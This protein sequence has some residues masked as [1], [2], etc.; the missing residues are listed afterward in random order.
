MNACESLLITSLFTL[1]LCAQIFSNMNTKRFLT[2][3]WTIC[4]VILMT[5]LGNDTCSTLKVTQSPAEI[6]VK[7]G[8]DVQL[9]CEWDCERAERVKIQWSKGSNELLSFYTA[10]GPVM[11]RTV[12]N[13]TDVK[14]NNSGL[15]VCRVTVE[16]PVLRQC[17][18]S[19]TDLTV[20]GKFCIS[21]FLN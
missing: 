21:S 7:V 14:A 9:F 19:G 3:F 20:D 2:A 13:V 15:Y 18:G 12:L 10:S 16:I 11:S 17:D 8:S 4:T 5:A 6:T 1:G